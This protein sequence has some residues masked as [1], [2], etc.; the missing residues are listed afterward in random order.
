M[1]FYTCPG[2]QK[3]KKKKG[4]EFGNVPVPQWLRVHSCMCKD[5]GLI[6]SATRISAERKKE[7]K[8]KKKKELTTL[9]FFLKVL[10]LLNLNFLLRFQASRFQWI[11]FPSNM[12]IYCASTDIRIK[13]ILF[14]QIKILPYVLFSPILPPYN[15]LF[16]LSGS[17]SLFLL[18]FLKIKIT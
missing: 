6:P 10:W 4:S 3:K 14:I 16:P 1:A 8:K 15:L 5:L 2:R 13:Q 9:S 12:V 17:C 11:I 18:L 7:K